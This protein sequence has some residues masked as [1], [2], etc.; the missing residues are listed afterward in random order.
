MKTIIYSELAPSPLG[1][2]SQAVLSNDTLYVSGQIA[3]DQSTGNFVSDGIEN[4][5]HQVMKNIGYVLEAAG[6]TYEN[7]V[8]CSIFVRDMNDFA[9]I[10]GVYATYFNEETAPARE[11]VQVARLPKDVGIEISCVAVK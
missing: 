2:Y 6:M 5:T 3:I 7:V 11:T 4:E 1:P 9:N 10:N 8:K